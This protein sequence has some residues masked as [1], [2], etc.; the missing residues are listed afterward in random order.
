[1]LDAATLAADASAAIKALGTDIAMIDGAVPLT[2]IFGRQLVDTPD[3]SQVYRTV[4][5]FAVADYPSPGARIGDVLVI[6]R[7]DFKVVAWAE[8]SDESVQ[9]A[10]LE[11]VSEEI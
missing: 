2:V 3:G 9:S 5:R 8:G 10:I 4:A 1:M 11:R 6:R 7:M